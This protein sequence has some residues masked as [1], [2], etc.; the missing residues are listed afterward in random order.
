M[1]GK[2]LWRFAEVL[3]ELIRRHKGDVR[4]SKFIENID[5]TFIRGCENHWLVLCQLLFGKEPRQRRFSAP[6]FCRDDQNCVLGLCHL[7][8]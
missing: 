6:T 5:R 2:L 8:Q 1:I 3:T 4:P 7:L